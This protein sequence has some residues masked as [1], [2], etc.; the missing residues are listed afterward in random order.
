MQLCQE[1]QYQRNG[2]LIVVDISTKLHI[3]VVSL[4]CKSLDEMITSMLLRVWYPNK[5]SE[6][7][8]ARFIL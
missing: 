6:S 4:Y 3:N 2:K 7:I 8:Y 5:A 1:G